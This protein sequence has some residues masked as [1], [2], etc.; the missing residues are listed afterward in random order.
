MFL[1]TGTTFE[2]LRAE[3]NMPEVKERLI[4]K[5]IGSDISRFSS[6]KILIEMLFGPADFEVENEPIIV[7]TSGV[8]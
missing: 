8:V 6:F 2:T 7:V 5:E 4:I 3:G 1:K